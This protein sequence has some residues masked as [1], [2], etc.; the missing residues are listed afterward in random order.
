MTEILNLT[1]VLLFSYFLFNSNFTNFLN[2]KYFKIKSFTLADNFSISIII[3][4]SLILILSFFKLNYVIILYIILLS[5][6]FF[7]IK[8][9]ITKN[10]INQ[11][12]IQSC[13]IY[14]ICSFI[15]SIDLITNLKLEWDGHVWFF[16]ALN[17]N[18]GFNFFNLSKTYLSNYPHLGGL[19]WNIFWKISFINSEVFGRVIF[20]IL[21]LISVFLIVETISKKFITKIL[22]LLSFIILTYDKFLFGGY[23][24]YLLFSFI[25]IT[26]SL[27]GKFNLK[28]LNFF[29]LLII[30]MSSNLLI[31]SKNEGIFYFILVMI[32]LFFYQ[33]TKNRLIILSTSLFLIIIKFYLI[34]L[35]S[36]DN[37][38]IIS[39]GLSIFDL[40]FYQKLFFVLQHVL[41]A[42]FK[43][44]IWILFF[45]L[46]LIKKFEKE[47]LKYWFFSLSSLIIIISVY[48]LSDTNSFEWFVTGSLDRLIFN[49]SGFLVFFISSRI[50]FYISRD[51]H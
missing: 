51:F 38:F 29:Q 49:S 40:L 4:F 6:I 41:I 28:N 15:I 47:D 33:N 32:Y 2:N 17:F 8:K 9:L 7:L 10:Q 5:N 12:Y 16:H 1:Y 26:L 24:E 36:S 23:Q 14:L 34:N 25:V 19:I 35:N 31:W 11:F 18:E 21:Y 50:K 13:L 20:I 22:L 37:V 43:Y 48:L 46:I 30:V 27:M 39:K 3:I 42:I 45:F 44:P